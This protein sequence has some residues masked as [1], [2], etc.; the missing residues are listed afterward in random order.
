MKRAWTRSVVQLIGFWAS[1]ALLDRGSSHDHHEGQVLTRYSSLLRDLSP[2]SYQPRETRAT[3]PAPEGNT[4]SI[5]K[6]YA[7]RT[8]SRMRRVRR[9]L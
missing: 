5:S 3:L 7:D 1:R 9:D 8:T 6:N 2:F 4:M